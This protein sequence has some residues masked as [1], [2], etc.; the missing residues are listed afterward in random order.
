MAKYKITTAI[1]ER[2]GY[3][4][5]FAPVDITARDYKDAL[6]QTCKLCDTEGYTFEVVNNSIL[7]SGI[8]GKIRVDD[9]IFSKKEKNGDTHYICVSQLF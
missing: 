8:G 7:L 1:K 2:E 6:A 9:A 3:L 5:I 4:Y